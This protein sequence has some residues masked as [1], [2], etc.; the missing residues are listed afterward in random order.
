MHNGGP[1]RSLWQWWAEG[2]VGSP[3]RRAVGPALY[4]FFSLAVV[5]GA[6]NVATWDSNERL[7]VFQIALLA[8]ISYPAGLLMIRLHSERLTEYRWALWGVPPGSSGEA[9]RASFYG[10]VPTDP[11]VRSSAARFVQIRQ[12]RTPSTIAVWALV[13]GFAAI[14]GLVGCALTDAHPSTPWFGYVA[15][16]LAIAVVTSIQPGVLQRRLTLLL[17]GER[18]T[19]PP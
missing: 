15:L 3:R 17:A 18:K 4:Q 2:L 1:A 5:L 19:P 11:H 10:A 16:L 9:L 7:D 14:T 8:I 13:A 12:Q 6:V